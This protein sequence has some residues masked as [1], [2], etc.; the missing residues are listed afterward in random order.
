[1]FRFSILVSVAPQ[2]CSFVWYISKHGVAHNPI[3]HSPHLT[4]VL[5][6]LFLA[7]HAR[8]RILLH[9]ISQC[10]IS[11]MLIQASALPGLSH[12]IARAGSGLNYWAEDRHKHELKFKI[13]R[14]KSLQQNEGHLPVVSHC[15]NQSNERLYSF[16]SPPTDC[17]WTQHPDKPALPGT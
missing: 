6:S 13:V 4:F 14:K 5:F 10:L 2:K 11:L 15:T 17:I 7:E 1:M 3:L 9:C 12:V 16:L 8:R